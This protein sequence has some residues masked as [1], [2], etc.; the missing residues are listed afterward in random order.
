MP[1][2][3]YPSHLPNAP[4][5]EAIF[6]LRWE[7]EPRPPGIQH[8]PGFR[9]LL[10]RYYDRIRERYP[11]AQD[12]A[13]S[14]VPEDLAAY[15]VRHQ[16]RAGKEA[17]PVTQLGP[18]ILTV[19]ETHAYEWDKFQPLLLESISATFESYPSDIRKF[20]PAHAELRYVNAIPIEDASAVILLDYLREKLHIDL[21]IQ[22][23]LF[24][25]PNASKAAG[26]LNLNLGYELDQPKGVGTLLFATG[27]SEGKPALIWQIQVR[28]LKEH[29]PKSAEEFEPWLSAAHG[30]IEKWFF[31]LCDGPLLESFRRK[32]E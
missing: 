19:N 21:S 25:N 3:E 32:P 31:T 23:D 15:A 6:E 17:W 20:T 24:E 14:Q 8:D 4:L 11:F 29:A 22:A 1:E 7:L 10:G 16:F 2:S 5:A 27:T 28:S 26:S 30:L 18:G 12:L 13:V 9:L